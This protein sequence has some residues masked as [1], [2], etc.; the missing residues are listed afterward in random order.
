MKST[1]FQFRLRTLMAVVV[2]A[3]L[4]SVCLAEN[5][6]V[7]EWQMRVMRGDAHV[8]V[9]TDGDDQADMMW[10]QLAN[11]KWEKM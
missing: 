5:R 3:S 10:V 4:V 2:L 8:T 11:G 6:L 1:K 7:S 9:G